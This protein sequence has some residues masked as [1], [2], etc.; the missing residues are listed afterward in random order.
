MIVFRRPI[1]DNL[2]LCD[3]FAI[4]TTRIENFILILRKSG[5]F[6]QRCAI[7]RSEQK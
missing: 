1:I 5:R 3:V 2:N 6:S 4:T 7:A